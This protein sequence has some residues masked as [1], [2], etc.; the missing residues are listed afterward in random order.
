MAYEVVVQ[1]EGVLLKELGW[2]LLLLTPL[3]IVQAMLGL[4]VV[5]SDDLP[6]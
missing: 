6:R 3:H 2:D 5:F 4:G 1:S